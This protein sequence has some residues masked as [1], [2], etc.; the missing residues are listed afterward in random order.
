MDISSNV[1]KQVVSLYVI[2]EQP[3]LLDWISDKIDWNHLTFNPEDIYILE[4]QLIIAIY[5]IIQ[6]LFM[7]WKPINTK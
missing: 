6:M 4:Y 3:K 5:Y 7:H 1:L 2:R